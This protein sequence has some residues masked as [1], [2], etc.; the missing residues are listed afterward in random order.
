VVGA[1]LPSPG[2]QVEIA[3][4][5]EAAELGYAV[6]LSRGAWL[7]D[8]SFPCQFAIEICKVFYSVCVCARWSGAREGAPAAGL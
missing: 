7:R 1:D 5:P 4:E 3:Q 8:S 6:I 2:A